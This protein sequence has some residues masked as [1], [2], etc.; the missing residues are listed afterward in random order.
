MIKK[1]RGEWRSI[2]KPSAKQVAVGTR[3]V[4][5]FTLCSALAISGLDILCQTVVKLFM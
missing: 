1:L 4:V 3:N 5:V 2:S